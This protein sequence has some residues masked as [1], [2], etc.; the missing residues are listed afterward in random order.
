MYSSTGMRPKPLHRRKGGPG[1]GSTSPDERGSSPR[2]VGTW[3]SSATAASAIRLRTQRSAWTS[4]G[5]AELTR[6]LQPQIV[7]KA[8]QRSR[9]GNAPDSPAGPAHAAGRADGESRKTSDI[10]LSRKTRGT[11]TGG[12]EGPGGARGPGLVST[13]PAVNNDPRPPSHRAAVSPPLGGN[14]VGLGTDGD[15][16]HSGINGT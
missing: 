7:Q 8:S 9:G 10:P 3:S 11:P 5:R 2:P 15:W 4:K 13:S 14:R 16:S 6:A 1:L 12:S